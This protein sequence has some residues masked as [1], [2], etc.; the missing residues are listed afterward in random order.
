MLLSI[1][2]FFCLTP[3]FIA[4][5]AWRPRA[6]W[7]SVVT[8][9]LA[10]LIAGTVIFSVNDLS[11]VLTAPTDYSDDYYARPWTRLPAYTA[12]IMFAFAWIQYEQRC[13]ARAAHQQTLLGSDS[14]LNGGT[15][16]GARYTDKEARTGLLAHE[17]RHTDG[18][19]LPGSKQ[20][21]AA[22][23]PVVDLSLPWSWAW[24]L[25]LVGIGLILVCYYVAFDKY[26]QLS[27]EK[28]GRLR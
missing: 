2:Q 10:S 21:Q 24:G 17:D 19:A 15:I 28:L 6:G 16:N 8:A 12:G 1:T 23:K 3:I 22:S 4:L 26:V 9:T 11:F 18:A 5:F 14:S 27:T 25:G 13:T 20:D 7:I